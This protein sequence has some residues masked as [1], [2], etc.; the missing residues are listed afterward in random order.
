MQ[1]SLILNEKKSG[2]NGREDNMS[3]RRKKET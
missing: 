2:E 3:M 1:F